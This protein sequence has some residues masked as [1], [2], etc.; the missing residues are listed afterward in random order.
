MFVNQPSAKKYAVGM[1]FGGFDLCHVGHVNLLRQAKELCDELIVCVSSYGYLLSR[2]KVEPV[3][4]IY[5]RMK[6]VELTGYADI[7]DIQIVDGKWPMIE[8]YNPD[9]LFVGDDWNNETYEGAEYCETV[10]LKR[11]EGV[12]TSYLRD[13][14]YEDR[15]SNTNIGKT[16]FSQ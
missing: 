1:T 6:L 2:K 3:L 5:D 14:I 8:M 4:S 15:C 7:V 9:V 11:T 13:K 16:P 12:S 10:Y